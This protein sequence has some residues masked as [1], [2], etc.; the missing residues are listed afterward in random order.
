MNR[1]FGKLE[2]GKIV[3]APSEIKIGNT[4]Y[5][6]PTDEQY[7]A[8]GWKRIIDKIHNK[9]G[10]WVPTGWK[11]YETIIER[12]Y[13]WRE[14]KRTEADFDAAMEEHIRRTRE[15]RG[16]M[17]REPSE[18]ISSSVP[19]WAQ[20]A[21]D[22]VRFRDAVMVYGLDILNEWKATGVEPSYDEFVANLPK[23]AWTEA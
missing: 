12:V 17:T 1:N 2:D 4:Y 3:Y 5:P 19:R 11:E 20:D 15:E 10:Y 9:I 22:F 18:Y 7:F 8:A 16:Y 23:I 13:E 6:A 21:A 14:T